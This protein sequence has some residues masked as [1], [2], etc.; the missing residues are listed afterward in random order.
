MLFVPLPEFV[1]PLRALV[2]VVPDDVCCD[3]LVLSLWVAPL[4]DP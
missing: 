2:P 1:V 4:E 3:S